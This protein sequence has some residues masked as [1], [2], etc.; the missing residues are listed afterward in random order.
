[1]AAQARIFT[2]EASIQVVGDALQTFGSSGYS[3]RNPLERTYRGARIFTI[4]GGTA[5]IP[6]TAVAS[7]IP[8]MKLP[9][10]RD[11]FS[12]PAEQEE[13]A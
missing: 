13:G 5:Q 1:L 3:R 10:S 11:G 12:R 6:S 9:Q 8:D 7:R 2:A 4:G